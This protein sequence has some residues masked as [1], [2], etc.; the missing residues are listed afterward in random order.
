[1]ICVESSWLEVYICRF[2]LSSLFSNLGRFDI[3]EL[4]GPLHHIRR[5]YTCCRPRCANWKSRLSGSCI[6]PIAGFPAYLPW[7]DFLHIY[8]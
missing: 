3:N 6:V 4:L 8:R 5:V 2:S 1:M 7:V